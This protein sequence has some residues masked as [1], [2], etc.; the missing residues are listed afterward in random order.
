MKNALQHFCLNHNGRE[1]VARCPECSQFF[2]RECI[3][4]HDDRVICA[5]CLK[6]VSAKKTRAGGR[7]ARVLR[8]VFLF[9]A[10]FLL[11]W[12]LFYALAQGLLHIPAEIHELL[13]EE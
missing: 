11:C 8:H 12:I 5:A 10:S 4:E 13:E 1:A 3:V 7:F 9:S 6:R 2:C